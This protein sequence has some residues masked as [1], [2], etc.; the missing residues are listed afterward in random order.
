MKASISILTFFIG[1]FLLSCS[2]IYSER[3]IKER[4]LI[5]ANQFDESSISIFYKWNLFVRG[6]DN[7]IKVSNDSNLYIC[8]YKRDADTCLLNIRDAGA[9]VH[10]FPCNFFLDTSRFIRFEVVCFNDSATIFGITKNGGDFKIADRSPV[11]SIFSA[12]NPVEKFGLLSKIKKDLGVYRIT[13]RQNSIAFY[14]SAEFILFFHPSD[15]KTSDFFE[16]FSTDG[17][18][19]N[20]KKDWDLVRLNRPVD[21]G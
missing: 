13:S 11:S 2:D 17:I 14:L 15:S 7:W 5:I 4:A 16:R 12:S 10:D 21:N 8:G 19:E 3:K 18:I 9:F 6:F 1:S 20:I